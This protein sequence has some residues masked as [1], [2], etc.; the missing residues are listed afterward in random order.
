MA[1]IDAVITGI[2]VVAP[3]GIGKENFWQAL[4]EGKDCATQITSFDTS[5]FSVNRAAEIQNFSIQEH[6]GPVKGLRNID[7]T[8]QILLVAAKQAIDESGII[9]N[10]SN[11]DSI[12][13]STGTTF[14]HLWSIIEFDTEVLRDGLEFSNPALF[15]STVLNAAS[16]Q[17]SIRFNIQGFNATI[18]TG[19][20]SGLDALKYAID[21][22]ESGRAETVFSTGVDALTSSLFFGFHHLG[23]MAGLG[24]VPVSCPFD[25]RRN[26]PL[27]GEAA[28]AFCVEDE[29]K[30][31]ARGANII[32]RICSVT[33][34]FDAFRMGKVHPQGEGIEKSIRSAL[35]SA[36]IGPSEIDY[37]SSC[38]NSS[39]SLDSIEVKVLKNVFGQQLKNIPVSSI[40]SMLGETFSA[41]SVLQIASCVG[42]MKKG[43]V[44]PTINYQEADPQ[45]DIDCVPNVSRKKTVKRA[46]VISSGPGGYNSAAVL[47]NYV[48]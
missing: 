31:K 9:I 33:P 43:F 44:P 27:L 1:H 40:K 10:D 41:A 15:P 3:S 17:I 47:E 42:A 34:Y 35:D 28:V 14:S 13:V 6:L 32:A 29:K 18:S 48:G 24:S 37:I 20:T 19:Y 21:A 45:C 26:G 4:K 2:G 38:A 16:S 22:I 23:Y 5:K 11:T 39:Q 25:K 46:L 8:T 7:R 12:A 30:A 36:G